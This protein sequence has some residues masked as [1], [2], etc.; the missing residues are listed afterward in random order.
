MTENTRQITVSSPDSRKEVTCTEDSTIAQILKE[1]GINFAK[2]SV[3]VD[4]TTLG[5]DSLSKS[6]KDLGAVNGSVI[7]VCVKLQNAR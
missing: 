2:A 7:A 1:Q 4:G 3:M 6:L 5:N